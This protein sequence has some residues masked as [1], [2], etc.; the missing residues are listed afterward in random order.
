[1]MKATTNLVLALVLLVAIVEIVRHNKIIMP[2]LVLS[3]SSSSKQLDLF[4][5]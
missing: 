5:F 1:M 2:L 3:D 4:Q